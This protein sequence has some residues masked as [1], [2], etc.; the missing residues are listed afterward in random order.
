MKLGFLATM[1]KRKQETRASDKFEN[2]YFAPCAT[3][4]SNDL[5]NHSQNFF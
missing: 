4:S 1:T 2:F 5:L 3:I